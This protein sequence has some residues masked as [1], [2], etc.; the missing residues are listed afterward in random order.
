MKRGV[1]HIGVACVF[2]CHDGQ[3]NILMHKR[4]ANCRDEQGAWDCGAG[5]MEFGETFEET[6][7]RELMEEYNVVPIELCQLYIR[8]TL[9]ENYGSPTHWVHVIYAVRIDPSTAKIGEPHK[10]DDIGWFPLDALPNPLHS[11]LA[12]HLPK[13][14]QFLDGQDATKVAMN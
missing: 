1:D 4:S 10:M 3:G 5:S 11:A 2:F 6:V 8:N 7:R 9:R 12:N 13:L 14:Q